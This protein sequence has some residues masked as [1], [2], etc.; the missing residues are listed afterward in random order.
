MVVKP[1][2]LAFARS[3][4]PANRRERGG[5]LIAVVGRLDFQEL[6]N[7][8]CRDT[9]Y[10]ALIPASERL[11]G[12]LLGFWHT[13]PGTAFPGPTDYLQLLNLNRRFRRSFALCILGR[14]SCSILSLYS[15]FPRL[16]YFS[17]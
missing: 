3:L 6:P 17:R 4:A 16:R 14:R 1:A 15:I 5:I 12:E 9:R 11:P 2:L 13:H 8:D 10:T 7:R